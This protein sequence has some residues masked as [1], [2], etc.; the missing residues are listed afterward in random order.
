[1]L[2]EVV[3]RGDYTLQL[4]SPAGLTPDIISPS[5]DPSEEIPGSLRIQDWS[6]TG[7]SHL[8][9][10]STWGSELVGSI[11]IPAASSSPRHVSWQSPKHSPTQTQNPGWHP[12]FPPQQLVG[13]GGGRVEGSG[14]GESEWRVASRSTVPSAG[15]PGVPST[16]WRSH[17]SM[18]D[19]VWMSKEPVATFC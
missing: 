7:I 15:R 5:E 11:D 19:D 2:V 16:S 4:K 14:T 17:S 1:M 8:S 12:Q 10:N 18:N 13:P 9:S 6:P 3:G